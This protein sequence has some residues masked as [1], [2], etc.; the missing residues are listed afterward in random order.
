MRLH[1]ICR[2]GLTAL[3][4]TVASAGLAATDVVGSAAVADGRTLTVA[5]QSFQ[6]LGIAVPAPGALCQRQD[7]PFDCGKVATSQLADL[8]VG[9]TV[10]CVPVGNADAGHRLA[11]CSVDGYD[12]SGG[13]VYTGWARA[14]RNQTDRFDGTEAEA[15]RA[16][17]G[18]WAKG[19]KRPLDWQ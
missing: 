12:L 10:R 19:I 16:G 17:R 2:A 11:R 9:A 5:G 1:F 8:T 13:M 7:R 18:L 14:D 15:R 3:F 6:L 4:L